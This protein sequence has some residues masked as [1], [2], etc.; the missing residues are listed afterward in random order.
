MT[1]GA[2]HLGQVPAITGLSGIWEF[3]T[4][5][6]D[7]GHCLHLQADIHS[8]HYDVGELLQSE[9]F[10]SAHCLLQASRFV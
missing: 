5:L 4:T 1:V 9:A 6:S 10:P 2:V 3:G 8:L 7:V